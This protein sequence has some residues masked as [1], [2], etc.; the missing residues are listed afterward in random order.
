MYDKP[1]P[2]VNVTLELEQGSNIIVPVEKVKYLSPG[3]T[4]GPIGAV[5]PISPPIPSKLTSNV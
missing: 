5:L 4:A 1:V 3:I 2:T